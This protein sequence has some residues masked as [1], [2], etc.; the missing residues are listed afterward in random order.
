MGMTQ[1]DRQFPP[2][3]IPSQHTL[4]LRAAGANTKMLG[5][6]EQRVGTHHDTDSANSLLV[7]KHFCFCC[8]RRPTP[9]SFFFVGSGQRAHKDQ[10]L[11]QPWW[12]P[13]IALQYEK[14][15]QLCTNP[16][17]ARSGQGNSQ[18]QPAGTGRISLLRLPATRL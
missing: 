4:S 12:T 1:L 9:T 2:I 17:R 8:R 15:T 7:M 10:T 3:K 16:K 11:G 13:L 18:T 6:S 14:T 5:I